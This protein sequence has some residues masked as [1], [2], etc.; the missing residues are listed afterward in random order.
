MKTETCP[1]VKRGGGGSM[2][3]RA[4][5]VANGLGNLSRLDGRMDSVKFQQILEANIAPSVKKKSWKWIM[6]VNTP[7]T[8]QRST[9]QAEGLTMTPTVSSAKRLSRE[10]NKEAFVQS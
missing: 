3:L 2:V 6:I 10:G 4:C 5:V 9:S 1:A 7:Q 8:P